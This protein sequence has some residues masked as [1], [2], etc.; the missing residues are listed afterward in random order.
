MSHLW[1]AFFA[2][3]AGPGSLPSGPMPGLQLRYTAGAVL[4]EL[5]QLAAPATLDSAPLDMG[6]EDH[7]TLAPLTV[8]KSDQAAGL[9]E[10]LLAIELLVARDVLTTAP[11][12]SGMGVGTAAVLRTIE[13]CIAA[14]DPTPDAVHRTLR[15]RFPAPRPPRGT[16]DAPHTPAAGAPEGPGGPGA[17]YALALDEVEIARYRGMAERARVAEADL[18]ERAGI[19]K[20][21]AVADVGCGPGAMLTALAEAVGPGG[22]VAAVDADPVAVAAA[23][24][25][26][27]TAGLDGVSVQ[28]G[29]AGRT[30][31]EAGAFDVVMLRHVLAHN[32]GAEDAIVAHHATL[33]RPGGCLYLVDA[34][35]T[36]VR[37]L[38]ED[39]DLT[40]LDGR[41]RALHQARGNDLRAGLHLAEW[42]ARAG[43]DLVEFRGSY[44]IWSL[45]P[46]FRP[47]SWAAREILVR[48]GLATEDDVARWADAFARRDAD[49][50][51]RTV[52]AP[53][54][55]ALGRRAT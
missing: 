19:V 32:G 9:L 39:P 31:L 44:V 6:V 50:A 7:A 38:P 4:P 12:R 2:R 37:T 16:G 20:G 53:M 21:A 11:Q 30:G 36:A 24:A 42:L 8:R 51:P 3:V 28:Q 25:L 46:S 17:P 54:F 14:A 26:A 49:P 47:P 5:K 34:D 45:P 43:L 15:T 22:R 13:E 52:F 10:D 55:V 40:D 29:G 33:L 41:Y 35:G 23:R 48:A 18:W 1:D 27:D